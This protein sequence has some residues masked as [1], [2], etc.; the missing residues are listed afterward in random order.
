MRIAVI[1]RAESE[2]AVILFEGEAQPVN[3]PLADL[4][5]GVKEGGHLQIEMQD[6]TVV[7]AEINAKAKDEA[8]KR[9]QAKLER[10]RRGDHVK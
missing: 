3:I 4:P 8:E 7:R 5:E 2:R 1:D 9:I 6:G 10:L